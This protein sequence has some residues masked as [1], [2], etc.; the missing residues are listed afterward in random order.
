M[1]EN[2]AKNDIVLK[3]KL[4]E[5]QLFTITFHSLMLDSHFTDFEGTTAIPEL[6]SHI[7]ERMPDVVFMPSYP[8]LDGQRRLVLTSRYIRY[9]PAQFPRYYVDLHGSYLEYVGKFSGK[10]RATLNRKVRKFVQFAGTDKC[11]RTYRSTD[12]ILDFHRLAREV[13]KNTYQERLL[14]RGLPDDHSYRQHLDDLASRDAVRGYI[15]FLGE[16]PISYLCCPERDGILIYEHLGYRQEFTSWSPGTVLL[17]LALQELFQEQRFRMLDFTEGEGEQKEFFSTGSV[18]CGDIYFFRLTCRNV[19]LV[20][21]HRLLTAVSDSIVK[22]LTLLK[23]K[24]RIK[25]MIRRA[26]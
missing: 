20:C 7:A 3:Y 22:L 16:Q 6:P 18:S 21:G 15:L 5:F 2:W 23:V 4:G 1:K 9:I 25:K 19:L 13:S 24:N 11:Y 10:S 14:G 26:V 8:V 12:E 17:C